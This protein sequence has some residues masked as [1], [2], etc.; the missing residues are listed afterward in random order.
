MSLTKFAFL[1]DWYL[2]LAYDPICSKR[3][4]FCTNICLNADQYGTICASVNDCEYINQLNPRIF[5][6]KTV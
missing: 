2:K 6:D 1:I 5:I 4:K 3:R